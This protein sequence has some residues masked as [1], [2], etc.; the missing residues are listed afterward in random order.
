[1][2]DKWKKAVD[3][4][5]LRALLTGL[6]KAFDCICH[7]LLVSKLNT[8]GVSFPTIKRIQDYVT[9]TGSKPTTT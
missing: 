9:A 6:S 1:M 4:K 3:E 8:Y 2:T 5:V 7:D